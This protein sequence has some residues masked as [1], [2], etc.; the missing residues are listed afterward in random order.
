LAALRAGLVAEPMR[1]DLR[2]MLLEVLAN[3]GAEHDF[4]EEALVAKTLFGSDS[5]LWQLAGELAHSLKPVPALFDTSEPALDESADPKFGEASLP[6]TE[7]EAVIPDAE[8][9]S[10]EPSVSADAIW[11]DEPA[12][13][14]GEVAPMAPADPEPAESAR[15]ASWAARR[16]TLEER[17]EHPPEPTP[18]LEPYRD[19]LKALETLYAKWGADNGVTGKKLPTK[20]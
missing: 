9:V 13:P 5:V 20:R 14:V 7:P 16:Q 1:Q 15:S 19:G 17:R 4:V 8:P 12:A 10:A 2:L 3:R 6:S 18:S 11:Q